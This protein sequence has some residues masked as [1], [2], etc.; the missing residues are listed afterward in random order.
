M[1][2]ALLL[3]LVQVKIFGKIR[4]IR[5]K[6]QLKLESQIL[7]TMKLLKVNT[8]KSAPYLVTPAHHNSNF[9]VLILS[10]LGDIDLVFLNILKLNSLYRNSISKFTIITPRKISKVS[11]PSNISHLN[12]SLQIDSEYIGNSFPNFVKLGFNRKNWIIQQYIKSKFVYFAINPVLIVDADTFLC[13]PIDWFYDQKN[14]I[15][16]NDSEFHVPYLKQV[17]RYLNNVSP[18]LNFVSHVQMQIPKFVQEIYGQDFEKGWIF[19]AKSGMVLG[20]TS[21]VSEFQTYGSYITSKGNSSLFFHNYELLNSTG[22]NLEAIKTNLDSSQS[23]L[24]TV[25]NKLERVQ[26]SFVSG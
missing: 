10:T 18:L 6:K 26:P 11:I 15:L 3:K 22:L 4:Q 17:E 13:K 16:V 2:K 24:V 9:E 19:W 7:L 12:I 25:G 23:D 20:E 1:P 8:C 5:G 21:P 14:V